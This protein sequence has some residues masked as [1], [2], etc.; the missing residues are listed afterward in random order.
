MSDPSTEPDG[1][2]SPA[3][4]A[5]LSRREARELAARQAQ[6]AEQAQQPDPPASAPSSGPPTLDDLFAQ[7]GPAGRGSDRGRRKRR[8]GGCLI[9]LIV[10]VAILGG[11]VAGGIW[12]WN[13]YEDQI[14]KVMGWEE[15]KDY[16]EGLATGEALVTIS[17]GDT[18]VVIS[19]SLFDAEVTKTPEAFYEYL[20]TLDEQPE[21]Y[22][23]VYRLQRMMT[24]E[25]A[26][27]A[28]QNPEN[29]LEYSALVREGL[30][31]AQT[32]QVLSE[33]LGIPYTDFEAA[34]T[35]PAAYGVAADSLEGWLFPA[36]YTFDP[37]VTAPQVIQRMVD[38]TVQS[39]DAAG[40]PVEERQR[41]LTIASII[42]REA[43]ITDDFYK[44]SRVIQN[45]LD[46]G[47]MLQMD[48][49]SQYGYGEM[50]SG[51][52]STSGEAQFHDNPWNTYVIEGLPI[53][54]IANPGD[55]AIDAAMHPADGPWLFFVTWNMDTGETIFTTTD[56][57]HEEA[58]QQWF[59]WCRDNDNRGC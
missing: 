21:F 38:R 28:L 33:S 37:G 59:Q 23:G 14:R 53:G 47:M 4:G 58:K 18:G 26:L 5:P 31:V 12:A 41:I 54:P 36:M 17:S 6:E 50:G 43:R 48:S 19:Q 42:E 27:A 13:T 1:T 22:P 44:V 20:I 51:S 2:P 39:L 46:I 25:A 15:P 8:G 49:T 55:T 24:S 57:E 35:D 3:Q 52:V 56:A 30:T 32:I 34:V 40:V 29:K 16:E 11:A 10:I 7:P 9:A 45:R